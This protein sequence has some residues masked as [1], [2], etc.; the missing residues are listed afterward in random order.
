MTSLLNMN[1]PE[2]MYLC[3][4][5]RTT[6]ADT[7]IF[8]DDERVKHLTVHYPG[9]LKALIAFTGIAALKDGTP[10]GDWLMETMRGHT[11][12]FDVSMAHLHSRLKRDFETYRRHLIVTVNVMDGNGRRGFGGFTN[13]RPS[14]Y[15]SRDFGYTMEELP[16]PRGFASGAP[17]A[18]AEAEKRFEVIKSQLKVKPRH[19]REHMN[20]LAKVNRR[21]AQAD[22]RRA[23]ATRV[24]GAIGTV[25]PFCHVSFVPAP[26]ENT[27]KYPPEDRVYT[28]PGDGVEPPFAWP[29][30]VNGID[31]RYQIERL[32]AWARD[33]GEYIFDP[34]EAQ[35]RLNRRP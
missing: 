10:V 35:R 17:A 28:L 20:M 6:D 9:D 1:K 25:S 13:Q 21:V 22:E 19:A 5:Y 8:I 34:E 2:G 29:M 7:G 27:T 12:V 16:E 14:G 3:A 18:K 24:D 23:R 26:G 4:D 15:I 11:E 31:T 32:M 33:G 30:L